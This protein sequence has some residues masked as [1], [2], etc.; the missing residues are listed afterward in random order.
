[1]PDCS[2][3]TAVGNVSSYTL[4]GLSPSTIYSVALCAI[5][6]TGA[7]SAPAVVS[8]STATAIVQSPPAPYSFSLTAAYDNRLVFSWTSGG[9]STNNFKLAIAAGSYAPSC[10]GGNLIGFVSSYDVRNLSSGTQYSAA[11]CALDSSG[12]YSNPVT[13]SG[14]TT[15][16]PTYPPH[17]PQT[18]PPHYPPTYPPHYPPTYP[19]T[20]PPHP[21]PTYPPT[22]PPA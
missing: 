21:S 7:S 12:N 3:G 5:D 22:Y 2:A 19:P 1:V 10:E 20:Y 16:P 13:A 17:Y 6:T 11:L 14:S 4:S 15:Y 18:Y 8:A 9:G